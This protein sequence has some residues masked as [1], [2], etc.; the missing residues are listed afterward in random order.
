LE[1]LSRLCDGDNGGEIALFRFEAW[2]HE[3]DNLRRAFLDEFV[4]FVRSRKAWE[5][6][7]DEIEAKLSPASNAATE[8]LTWPAFFAAL[9]LFLWLAPA[10]ALCAGPA[11]PPWPWLHW[12]RV[13]SVWL[14][15]VG[16]VISIWERRC[17]GAL[18]LL[19][20][21]DTIASVPPAPTSIEF[22]DLFCDLLQIAGLAPAK[23]VLVVAL[24]DF[25]RLPDG[26]GS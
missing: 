19:S 8:R 26:S 1:L 7:L 18:S 25:D 20:R 10:G 14:S 5:A 21:K 6:D 9:A 4:A 23:R 2:A 24:E 13:A 12:V 15:L 17:E 22:R 11:L 3:G 16:F